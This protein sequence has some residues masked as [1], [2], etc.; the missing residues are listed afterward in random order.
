MGGWA[1]LADVALVVLALAGNYC[2]AMRGV[3]LDLHG[4]TVL[5]ASV[6]QLSWD[7]VADV[8]VNLLSLVG[9]MLSDSLRHSQAAWSLVWS[10]TDCYLVGREVPPQRT[11]LLMALII[12]FASTAVANAYGVFTRISTV[13]A[14]LMA[15]GSM[16]NLVHDV[17][18][19]PPPLSQLM[20]PGHRTTLLWEK[21]CTIA[22]CLAYLWMLFFDDPAPVVR[23]PVSGDGDTATTMLDN[24]PRF[25]PWFVNIACMLISAAFV[26]A[27]VV[28]RPERRVETASNSSV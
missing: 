2:R 21:G 5:K 25:W 18:L 24:V 22:A 12:V 14:W 4:I 13:A 8:T 26:V 11:F 6:T 27:R 23:S 17:A 3:G 10:L 20:A 16:V 7:T 9:T 28:V 19:F 1:V 15:A